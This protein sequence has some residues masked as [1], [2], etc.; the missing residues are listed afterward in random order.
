[1]SDEDDKSVQ[2]RRFYRLPY[3]DDARPPFQHQDGESYPV[4]ELS[5][6]SVV[7]APAEGEVWPIGSAVSGHIFFNDGDSESISGEVLRQDSRGVVVVLSDGIT[8]HH[9]IKEQTFVKKH[10][11]L[12]L[13]QK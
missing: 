3:P 9:V 5:E 4:L 10:Y 8:F 13:R 7:I 6:K 11:P 12:F 2:R 1:M